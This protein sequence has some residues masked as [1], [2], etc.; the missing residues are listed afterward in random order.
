MTLCFSC[1]VIDCKGTFHIKL[2][3]L[4]KFLSITNGLIFQLSGG[5]FLFY[6]T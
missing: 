2:Y 4:L 3:N 6:E 1:H 5:T